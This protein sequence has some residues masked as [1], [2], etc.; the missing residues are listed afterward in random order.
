MFYEFILNKAPLKVLT[1]LSL[2]AHEALYE[3]EICK[4]TGLAV[5]TVN[6][7][8]RELQKA[9]VVSV[10][11]KGRMNFYRTSDN[12][13]LIR[14]HRVWDNLLKAQ[15]LVQMLKPFCSRIILFG[16]CAAGLD[17]HDSDFDIAL[18]SEAPAEKLRKIIDRD[19]NFS[20]I[21]KP[22]IYTL[23]EYASLSKDDSSFYQELQKGILL[24]E[25]GGVADGDEL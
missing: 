10:V 4:R 9:G 25:K 5:G 12:L 15:P 22:V 1:L 11:R 7:I 18:V 3:R 8:L 20:G 24:H 19:P 16:S 17:R 6:Q 14:Q 2:H 23:S 21:I 13:P